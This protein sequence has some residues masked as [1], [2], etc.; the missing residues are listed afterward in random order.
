MI[1]NP[2]EFLLSRRFKSIHDHCGVFGIRHI[3]ETAQ[4]ANVLCQGLVMLQHRGQESAGISVHDGKVITTHKGPGLVTEVFDAQKRA[5]VF[6]YLGIGHVRYSTA[7]SKSL[8]EAQP[9]VVQTSRASF[10]F[11]FNGNISNNKD[12]RDQLL[13][14][15]YVFGTLTD[16]E[17]ITRIIIDSFNG[18]H[19]LVGA[20]QQSMERLAGAYSVLLLTQEGE[21]LAFR[22]PLG[23]RPLVLGKTNE[24]IT[25]IASE[26][27]AF[28]AK[29]GKLVSDVK[30]GEL[31]RIGSD[32]IKRHQL[33][34]PKPKYCMFEYVYFARPDSNINGVS[35][36]TRREQLGRILAQECPVDADVIVPVPDS[37]RIAALG[38]SD[39]SG[40]PYR[41][42]LTKNRFIWRTF[43]MP[44]QVNREKAVFLKLNVVKKLI[45]GK[46]IVL[47]DD[48]IVRGTT[49]RGM[50]KLLRDGGAREVHVR[51][52]CPPIIAPC[53]MGIDFP[54]SRELI[55]AHK[56]PR[57]I[58]RIIGADSVEYM[59][60]DGLVEALGTPRDHLCLACLTKEYPCKIDELKDLQ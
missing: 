36:Y 1:L 49:M 22:D 17:V 53:F 35:V 60:I 37:G 29:G 7:G 13:R 21:I 46:R 6:G 20:I 47:I 38:F 33:I 54:T 19:D 8:N 30:P 24:G 48:S 31:V 16:T 42:G 32:G 2:P 4:V 18:T 52:S 5:D 58:T 11:A 26:D 45:H 50:V 43:I 9:L 59:S 25:L 14:K 39:E 23:I 28:R 15:G 27:V 51:S 3:D 55:A 57:D 10:A 41:E 34:K 40:I 56:T 12:L 44:G